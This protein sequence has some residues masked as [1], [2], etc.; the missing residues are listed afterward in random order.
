MIEFMVFLA[1]LIPNSDKPVIALMQSFDTV[2][3]CNDV[4]KNAPTDKQWAC[5]KI[6]MRPDEEREVKEA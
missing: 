2:R 3:E 5:I 4:L 6:D 1:L